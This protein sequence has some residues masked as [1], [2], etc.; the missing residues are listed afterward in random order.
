MVRLLKR[1]AP[2]E[3]ERTRTKL[4]APLPPSSPH[5]PSLVANLWDVTDRDIDRL[6]EAVF[7]DLDI[8]A[9]SIRAA[10]NGKASGKKKKGK[11]TARAVGEA[12]DKCKLRFLTGA[13]VVVYGVPVRFV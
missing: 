10:A 2:V 7:L 1:I 11:T 8:Q 5:S 6:S 13:A 9:G 12:R 4:T 3:T